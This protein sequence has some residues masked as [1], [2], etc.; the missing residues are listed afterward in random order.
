MMEKSKAVFYMMLSVASL[1]LMQ[2]FINLSGEHGDVFLQVFSRNFLGMILCIYFIRKEKVSYFG[3]LK[4]QP[5]LLA[6]SLAGFLGLLFTFYAMKHAYLADASIVLRTGPFFTTL[7]SV[8]FLK[9]KLNKVQVPVLIVIFVG[10]WLAANPRFDS[11]FIPL[12]CALL[13]AV[14]QGICYPLLR[15]FREHEHGMTVIMHFSTFC[16]LGCLPFMAKGVL[17]PEG[18]HILYLIL[19][20]IT[21]ALGQIFLTYAYRIGPASEIAIYD[22]FSVVF[23]LVLG[24]LFLNQIPTMRT[25][26]GGI[27]IVGASLVS[28]FFSMKID[29]TKK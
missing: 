1:S 26:V 8:I 15:Y 16:C 5:Y 11:S 2:F 24:A 10:G 4:S 12:G 21:G 20:A 28:Y 27:L 19:I 13:A 29:I 3:D 17:M 9:E 23:A 6:R 18:I 22:Q 14:C 7:V 25:M